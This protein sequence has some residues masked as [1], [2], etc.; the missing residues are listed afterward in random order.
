MPKEAR[1]A[2]VT[3]PF[4]R[5]AG[6][7]RQLVPVLSRFW[8]SSFN[9]YVEPF[10]GSATLFFSLRPRKALLG[11]SNPELISAFVEVKYRA[12]K[13]LDILR[14]MPNNR[15]TYLR[16]RAQDPQNLKGPARAARFVYLNRFCFNGLYRTNA[17]GYFNV[18]YGGLKSGYLPSESAFRRCAAAMRATRFVCGDFAETLKLTKRGD[19]VYMDPPYSVK[20]RRVF[21]EY[22]PR[23]FSVDDF[24]RLRFW[25]ERLSS[26]GV[27]FVVSYADCKE[28]EVL[29]R[30]FDHRTV[31]V[32]RNI[33]GFTASRR[34]SREVLIFN[35]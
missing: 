29:A 12:G 21:N 2:L 18:P 24:K 30:G 5:W 19:F 33:S 8:H 7:K 26:R 25:M 20:G 22:G 34:N 15:R 1:D 31:V 4:L 17:R 16:V 3:A 9:R 23:S 35:I 11:D 27:G 10:A 13:V 28:A 32:R 14:G 6:S